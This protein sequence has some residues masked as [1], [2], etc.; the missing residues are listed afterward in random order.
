MKPRN[1]LILFAVLVVLAAYVFLVEV[2]KSKQA[3]QEDAQTV[4][5]WDIPQEAITRLEAGKRDGQKLV[6]ERAED[7]TW[8]IREPIVYEADANRVAGALNDLVTLRS[9]RTLTGTLNLADYGLA[10]PTM[11]VTLT[12]AD[13]TSHTLRVGDQNPTGSY[14]YMMA[15]DRPEVH[16]VSSWGISNLEQIVAEP[17]KKPTPTP[18]PTVTPTPAASPVPTATPTV[19]P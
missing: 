7:Q 4:A 17:P 16:L 13:G 6:L 3:P 10:T 5:L 1:T 14:R 19:A 11:T 18:T 2:P 12:L 8:W 15:D 9:T